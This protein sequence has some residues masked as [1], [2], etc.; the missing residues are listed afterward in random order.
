MVDYAETLG[1]SIDD[2]LDPIPVFSFPHSREPVP[3]L[4]RLNESVMIAVPVFPF[5]YG[6]TNGLNAQ[7][8]PIPPGG[9]VL[10]NE[11]VASRL[12]GH[13]SRE[14]AHDEIAETVADE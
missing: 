13:S 5:V 11:R 7:A 8:L 3:G 12:S 14:V 10:G 1:F 9:F 2:R 6:I 4:K